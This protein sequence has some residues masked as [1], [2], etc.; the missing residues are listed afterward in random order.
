[1]KTLRQISYLTICLALTTSCKKDKLTGDN[2]VL[3]GSWTSTSTLPN[4]GTIPGQPYNPN[5]KLELKEKGNYKL[6]RGDKKIET[7]RLLIVNGL[8][9]FDCREKNSELNARKIL[10]FNADTLN[11]DRNVCYDDYEFR[12]VKN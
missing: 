2:Q 9:T 10:K 1:M 4:C 7:G 12:F 8:V 11:I 3:V 6:F 5:F